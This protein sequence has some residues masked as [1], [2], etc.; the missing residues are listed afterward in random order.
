VLFTF[1]RKNPRSLQRLQC[2]LCLD[3]SRSALLQRAENQGAQDQ[4]AQVEALAED[5]GAQNYEL[6]Q[7]QDVVNENDDI[8]ND[9][10]P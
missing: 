5:Q 6:Q 7:Q 4:G 2:C 8:E 1:R 10:V 9:D 3:R